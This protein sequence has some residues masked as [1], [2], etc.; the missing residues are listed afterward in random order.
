MI[1]IPERILDEGANLEQS[2]QRWKDNLVSDQ[3]NF[4]NIKY[5]DIICFYHFCVKS[6]WNCCQKTEN[7]PHENEIVAAGMGVLDDA[8]VVELVVDE[9][10]DDGHDDPDD[11]D[12]DHG[13][14]NGH[15]NCLNICFDDC[16]VLR[17]ITFGPPN[18]F[19]T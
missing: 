6:K 1:Q 5:L 2:K 11:A 19:F 13:N 14:I 16:S 9:D 12:D 18:Q 3:N 8:A 7:V 17:R 10:Q 4:F 15:G